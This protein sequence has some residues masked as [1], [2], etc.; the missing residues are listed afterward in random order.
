MTM[1]NTPTF[2][3]LPFG[4]RKNSEFNITGYQEERPW[5]RFTNLLDEDFCKVKIIEIKPGQQPSYQYH[6][7]RSEVWT[8]VSGQGTV[9]LSGK[10]NE[11][12]AG[13]VVIVPVG[14]P[15][16]IK[17]TS[18]TEDLIF[19]EVQKGSYFGEDDIVRLEDDYDRSE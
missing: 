14:E 15:H 13:S 16:R 18:E 12:S 5:G 9:T 8:I 17:N 3:K 10:T 7:K 19:I 4:E 6:H 2:T 1:D 11:V